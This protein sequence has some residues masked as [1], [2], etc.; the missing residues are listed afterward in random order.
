MQIRNLSPSQ[1]K[2]I[3]ISLV[4]VLAFLFF[5]L[6]IYL[7]TKN[8]V[9]KIKSEL[10]DKE[11][12]IQEIETMLGDAKSLDEGIRLLK[13]R[14]QRINK[15]FPQK[16][17]EGIKILSDFARKLNI[18]ILSIEPK[19]KQ[20]F[21]DENN[22]KVTI[23]GMTCQ[24]LLVS[25]E[26]SCLYKDLVRYIQVLKESLPAFFTIETLKINKDKSGTLRLNVK[27][28]I[29]LYILS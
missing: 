14:H 5:L 25:I 4:V 15:K 28:D 23:E 13:E 3:I 10:F 22:N 7:P 20:E 1:K 24:S 2:I 21:L 18:Q 19:P 8:T 6:F 11:R 29:N 17:E 26:M 27:F 12:Q 9:L 16:E